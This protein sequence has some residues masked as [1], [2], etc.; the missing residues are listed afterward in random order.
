MNEFSEMYHAMQSF[1]NSFPMFEE[2]KITPS[3]LANGFHFTG[4]LTSVRNFDWGN[5]QIDCNF[6]DQKW[7]QKMHN[8]KII[9]ERCEN[10]FS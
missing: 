8:L 7:T 10:Y 6:N 3:V 9:L 4:V 1:I 5:E 2:Y